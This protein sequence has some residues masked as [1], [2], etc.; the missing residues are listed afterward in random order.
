MMDLKF[1]FTVSLVA[2]MAVTAANADIASTTYYTAGSNISIS[3]ESNGKKTISASVPTVNNATL[4]I[5]K[6]G[7]S[8]G[9]FTANASEAKTI[10]ITVPTVDTA[11]SDTSTN[12]VQ[13]KIV[14]SALDAKQNAATAVKHTASTAAG[15]ETRPVYVASNGQATAVTGTSVPVGA[16]TATSSTTWASIWIEE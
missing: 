8:V 4:T 13:N 7:T 10:D 11:L 6:N 16:A 2:I 14:K 9:T 1:V 12:A 5:K 15:G 3:A